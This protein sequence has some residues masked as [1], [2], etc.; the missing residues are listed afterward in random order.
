[1]TPREIERRQKRLRFHD[2]F[3]HQESLKRGRGGLE[4]LLREAKRKLTAAR[5]IPW[6]LAM[7]NMCGCDDNITGAAKAINIPNTTLLQE[8]PAVL[9]R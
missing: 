2:D 6:G 9:A 4:K 3:L 5:G 1:M 8:G 7:I